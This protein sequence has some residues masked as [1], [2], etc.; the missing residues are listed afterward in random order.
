[1]ENGVFESALT[2]F[3]SNGSNR[4][5]FLDPMAVDAFQADVTVTS[6]SNTGALPVAGLMGAFC[7]DGTPG[8]GSTGDVLAAIGIS[9][10]GTELV[11]VLLVGRCDD[12][13]CGAFTFFFFDDTTLGPVALDETHRLSLAWDGTTFTFGF[14]DE[15]VEFDPTGVVPVAG[16]PRFPFKD[17]STQVNGIDGPDVGASISATFDN[18]GVLAID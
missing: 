14:D 17:I 5:N 18:V 11:G 7:N 9:H 12:P 10:N 16:P 3:G 2:R 15:T 13:N 1:M 8:D 6:V 4:L